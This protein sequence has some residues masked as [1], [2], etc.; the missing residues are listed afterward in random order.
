MRIAR[1]SGS[2]PE[3]P[4]AAYFRDRARRTADLA[5]RTDSKRAA[6]L[7]LELLALSEL[8]ATLERRPATTGP[9]VQR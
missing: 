8:V 6:I 9:E 5:Y 3:P 4:P 7:A 1:P 2:A